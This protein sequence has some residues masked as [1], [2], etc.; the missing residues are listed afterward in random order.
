MQMR[1]LSKRVRRR[2][3]P[4]ALTAEQ[5]EDLKRML[6]AVPDGAGES[7]PAFLALLEYWFEIPSDSRPIAAPAYRTRG[8]TWLT[9]GVPQVVDVI[10]RMVEAG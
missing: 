6:G 9:A 10:T 5:R 8:G 7:H 3:P 4:P 2:Q 1:Y